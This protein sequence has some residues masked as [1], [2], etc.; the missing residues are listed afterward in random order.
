MRSRSDTRPARAPC[1][2]RTG[3][4]RKRR[5][6]KMSDASF[7]D[8]VVGSVTGSRVIQRST[9]SPA[10]AVA[11]VAR[12]RSRSVRMPAHRP[13]S[14]TTTEP[15]L[16]SC[17]RAATTFKLSSDRA[18]S[19]GADISSDNNTAATLTERGED[20]LE[21][22]HLAAAGRRGHED[23]RHPGLPPLLHAISDFSRAA[24]QGHVGQPSLAHRLAQT[25]AFTLREH[26]LDGIHLVL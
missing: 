9:G 16:F 15:T 25:L 23:G 19:T 6:L 11:A 21:R 14:T 24:G 8:A 18:V 20:L 1:S 5:R 2:S 13:S 26:R 7:H 17:I 10:G 3:M 12:N 22:L 4:W